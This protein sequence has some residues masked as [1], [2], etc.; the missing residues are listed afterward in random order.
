MD[1]LNKE[2]VMNKDDVLKR[3]YNI[4]GQEQ[5]DQ[6]IL[7]PEARATIITKKVANIIKKPVYLLDEKGQKIPARDEKGN[8]KTNDNGEMIYVIKDYE[9]KQEGWIP[10]QEI[11]PAS[12]I[13]NIDNGT[14]NIS[15]EAV[16]FQLKTMWRYNTFCVYQQ[17]TNNDYSIYLHKLRNDS[18]SVINS[19]KSFN[20]ST[21]QA[22]K[23]FINK[24]D[25]KQWLTQGDEEKKGGMFGGLFGGN[26]KQKPEGQKNTAFGADMNFT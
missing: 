1:F 15:H 23:T 4:W 21:I 9:E 6:M 20:G 14:G 2:N 5:I 18:L 17:T 8:I 22:I 10:I 25:T 12:E 16:L 13:F 26:K 11:L 19:S 7:T 24:T 3:G